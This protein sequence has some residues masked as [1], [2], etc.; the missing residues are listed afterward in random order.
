MILMIL[1]QALLALPLILGAYI[2]LSL[3]KLPDFSL[4]SAYLF[5]AVAA[6]FAHRLALPAA[7]LSAFAGGAFVGFIT[8]TLHRYFKLPFLLAAI[9]TNGLFH[10]LTQFLLG[11]SSVS[12]HLSS[13]LPEI[14]LLVL[15]GTLLTCILMIIN[16]SEL[17]F[18]FAIYGNNPLFFR[19]HGISG[20]FVMYLGVML[21]QGF[22]GISGCL[23]AL[24]NGFL[25]LTMNFGIVL[26][27]LTALVL[28]KLCI[29]SPRPH[30]LVPLIGAF[31]YFAVQHSL[32]RLGLN[33]TYFN[34]FQA[35][36][37]F[38]ILYLGH[39]NKKTT[40]DHLGV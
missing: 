19:H 27:S 25:D 34:S 3:L 20:N 22:A 6:F 40:L 37:V 11:A 12:F 5:G 38:V 26:L 30:I 21:G 15:V 35:L 2:I 10:G 4:E 36:F 18:S 29:R 32:L 13:Q 39:K 23:F 1:E 31:G 14:A 7:L 8:C 28:G 17:G 33:L 16:R 9:V 24:S